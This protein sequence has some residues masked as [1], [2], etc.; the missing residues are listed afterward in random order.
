MRELRWCL[1]VCAVFAVHGCGDE[2]AG[3]V[4]LRGGAAVVSFQDGQLPGTGYAGTRDTMLEGGSPTSKNGGDASLSVE[5]ESQSVALLAWDLSGEIPVTGVVEAVSVTLEVSDRSPQEF[6]LFAAKRAW[7]EGQATWKEYASGSSWQVGGAHGANDRGDAALGSFSAPENG[8]YTIPLNAAGI[9]AVQGWVAAPATNRGFVL[10][11]A[12]TDN[13]LEFRSSEYGTKA[14]RPR[15]T[16]TWHDGAGEGETTGTGTTGAETTGETGE[17]PGEVVL[18]PTPG[19][20]KQTCDGSFGVALDANYFIDGNDED[21]G[22]RVYLRGANANAAKTVDVSAGLG[23]ASSDEVDLEDAARIGDRIYVVSSHGRN[24]SGALERT[25]YRFFAV[26]VGGTAP[27]VTLTTVGYTS[28]LLDEMI[29]SA[30]WVTPNTAVIS[31]LTTATNFGKSTDA[32]LAPKVNGANIEGLAWLP[33]AQRPKQLV[34]GFRNPLQGTD[35]I[36]VTLLNADAVVTGGKPQ[37]GEA[38]L[39]NLGG[40][41]VRGMAWS[42]VHAAVLILA[43]PKDGG[44]P[45]RL[46]RWGG[47]DQAAALVTTISG[48]PS[49]AGP[50][51]I[52]VYP[53]TRDVQVLFDQ[54]DHLISGTTCK[55][56]SSSSRYFSDTIVHVP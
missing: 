6:S 18:D 25:R 56:K 39:L 23:V 12:G 9:A 27:A 28:T 20:Y 26:D 31:A 14:K 47:P 32:N 15:L 49:D 7:S 3:D 8:S 24:K 40:L 54:G 48:A 17:E 38:H 5:E 2:L 1:P 34:L 13:R 45:F 10:D 36:L 33:T 37:F 51:A 46:Y 50:E 29:K 41:R 53:N 55:D 52:V 19:N 16:I 44:G 11:G 21:Q 35:A 42:A 22:L 30:N 43:G 4:A